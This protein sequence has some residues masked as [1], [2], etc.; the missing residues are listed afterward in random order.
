LFKAINN[1]SK[2][3]SDRGSIASGR[4]HISCFAIPTADKYNFFTCDGMTYLMKDGNEYD[5][6]MGEWNLTALPGVTSRQGEDKLIPVTNWRGYCSK[7]NFAAAATSGGKNAACG[8][9]FEKMNASFKKN[10]ND[11]TGRKDPNTI[12]YGVKAYKSYF[13]DQLQK[14]NT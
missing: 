2:I 12:I 10:V 6:A 4:F 14:L 8:F 11:H 9:I 5:I 3:E 1:Y 13:I 7:Y